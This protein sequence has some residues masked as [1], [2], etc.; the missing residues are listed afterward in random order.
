MQY[1]HI[2]GKVKNARVY[3][4]KI[5]NQIIIYIKSNPSINNII[6]AGDINQDIESS[7]VQ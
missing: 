2:D 4:N 7:E 3:R 5:F 6:I 1:N